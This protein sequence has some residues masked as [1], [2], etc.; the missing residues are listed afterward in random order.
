[1]PIKSHKKG[2]KSKKERKAEER[3]GK[4]M[5]HPE[6]YYSHYGFQRPMMPEMPWEHMYDGPHADWYSPTP[7]WGHHGYPEPHGMEHMAS[8]TY[9]G[10]MPSPYYTPLRRP[11][12][13]P[14]VHPHSE[15]RPVHF[16]AEHPTA[17]PVKEDPPAHAAP[18][19]P[20]PALSKPEEQKKTFGLDVTVKDKPDP[21]GEGSKVGE[22]Y[23]FEVQSDKS[24]SIRLPKPDT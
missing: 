22:K 8:M 4:M 18:D 20:K 6:R 2:K 21:H 9:P 5:E 12:P 11:S 24:P 23:H 14:S 7:Y 3:Y 13:Y 10:Y 19:K 17:L 1:M 16:A 15:S